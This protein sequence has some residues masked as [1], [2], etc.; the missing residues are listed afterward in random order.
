MRK[1]LEERTM[2]TIIPALFLSLQALFALITLQRMAAA[3][4]PPAKIPSAHR[5]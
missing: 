2:S 4:K 3:E 5:S 1:A